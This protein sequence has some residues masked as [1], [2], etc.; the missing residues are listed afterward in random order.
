MLPSPSSFIPVESATKSRAARFTAQVHAFHPI[1]KAA[2]AAHKRLAQT[3][4]VIEAMQVAQ[5]E[6]TRLAEAVNPEVELREGTLQQEQQLLSE[7]KANPEGLL[8]E[9]EWHLR[10]LGRHRCA[11]AE[12]FLRDSLC[13]ALG[14]GPWSEKRQACRGFIYS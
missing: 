1:D 13:I 14:A 3:Q 6:A 12:A 4:V 8:L 9:G 10:L 11:T 5:D 7:A 2:L